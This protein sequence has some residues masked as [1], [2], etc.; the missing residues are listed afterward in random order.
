[1][2]KIWKALIIDDEELARKRLI[3]LMTDLPTIDI[4]GEAGN[5]IEGLEQ[6]EL[7]EPDLIFLDIEMPLLNGFEMLSKIK[8]PPKVIF[9]TAYD[10]YAVKAFEE[11]SIDYLLKPIEKERLTKAVNKLKSLRQSPDYSIP[12]AMLMQQLKIR[13]DIKTLT[14][15]I[16]DRIL[17][18]K[19][20]DLAFIDAEDK[21]VF[22]NTIDGK[23]H[24]TDF[25]ITTL[26]EKLKEMF[27]R[28]SRSTLINTDL[29]KEIRKSFNG[30]YFFMMTDF[31]NTKLNSSRSYGPMLKERFDL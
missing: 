24:L 25:T 21:Y 6:I 29:I 8:N 14:V 9:T 11:E 31:H 22:L 13:K 15:K 16:G 2:D 3:R 26:E 28:I 1:M 30:C 10:Q 7:L 12:L 20:T 18:I 23:R 19:L 4:I 17:L 27:V 5:G